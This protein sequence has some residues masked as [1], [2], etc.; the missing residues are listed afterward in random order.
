MK[1]ENKEYCIL[2]KEIDLYRN[3]LETLPIAVFVHSKLKFV[4]VN[5][6]GLKVFG[7]DHTNDIVGKHLSDFIQLNMGVV[8]EERVKNA[9]EEKPFEVI[10]EEH[11]ISKD[12]KIIAVDLMSMPMELEGKNVVLNVSS[13][14]N[15][16][17]EL[18]VLLL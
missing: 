5:K 10:V 16:R 1:R 3:I 15:Q 8:G 4:Y 6:A 17:E 2:N 14:I 11:L 13:D 12:G 9:L 7:L 18:D